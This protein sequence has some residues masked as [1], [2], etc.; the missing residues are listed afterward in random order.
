MGTKKAPEL[1]QHE[2]AAGPEILYGEPLG[3]LKAHIQEAI[4]HRAY[5]FFAARGRQHGLD[6]DDWF[7]SETE[8]LHPVK[9]NTWESPGE[10]TV[11]AEI[12]GFRAE[13]LKIGIAPG[14][15]IL[16]GQVGPEPN[17][18][19]AYPTRAPLALLHTIDL[20][21]V[22]DPAQ[23]SAAFVD[24]LLKLVLPKSGVSV[25]A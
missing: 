16:W 13:E 8:L 19:G 2:A 17:R 6:L 10:I 20:P 21:G 1:Q 9:V 7:R 18:P 25:S 15:V 3:D 24:S 14:S 4:A 11:T 5:E 23:A 22:V 12:P